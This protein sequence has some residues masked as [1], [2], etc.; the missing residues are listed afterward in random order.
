LPDI[1]ILNQAD[2]Q[3]VSYHSYYQSFQIM[4]LAYGWELATVSQIYQDS[5]DPNNDPWIF[6]WEVTMDLSLP[7]STSFGNLPV[8]VQQNLEAMKCDTNTMF[9]IQQLYLNLNSPR[10]INGASPSVFSFP[11][12]D[13]IYAS[14]NEFI[15]NYW[16]ILKNNGGVIFNTAIKPVSTSDYPPSSIIPTAVNFVVS[17][18][19]TQGLNTL[20]YLIMSDGRSFPNP[21]TAFNWSWVDSSKIQGIMSVRR[22]IFVDYLNKALS[23][24][25][26]DITYYPT[27]DVDMDSRFIL[28]LDT[29]SPA[30]TYTS[31]ASNPVLNF[32]WNQKSNDE[33]GWFGVIYHASV[34]TTVS[35]NVVFSGNKIICTTILTL[36]V[37]I[38]TALATTK[39]NHF[40]DGCG[41]CF[42]V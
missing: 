21:I 19:P 4:E 17:P 16:A 10:L 18:G 22:D 31:C 36:Y 25:L 27:V 15:S 42:A 34:E 13:P 9:S 28:G 29:P 3:A 37:D 35:S 30:P 41:G 5:Y 12:T 33:A 20:D 1:L 8:D 7:T 39:C 11:A 32:S 14:L 26:A 6:E 38:F 23:P 2:P 24:A 40:Y